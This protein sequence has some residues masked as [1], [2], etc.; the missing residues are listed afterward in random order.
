VIS[1]TDSEVMM[2]VMGNVD[3]ELDADPRRAMP[4]QGKIPVDRNRKE[5]LN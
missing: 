2:D 3:G 1:G 5:N 4:V